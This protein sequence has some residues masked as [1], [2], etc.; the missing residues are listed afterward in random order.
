MT[1]ASTLSKMKTHPLFLLYKGYESIKNLPIKIMVSHTPPHNT[2]IDIVGDGIHV[3][4]TA[5]RKF[6]DGYLKCYKNFSILDF[7]LS[8]CMY[9][10][11]S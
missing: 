7:S 8:F 4:S 2:A 10:L 3:G 6:I 11:T 5:V 9:I 1:V